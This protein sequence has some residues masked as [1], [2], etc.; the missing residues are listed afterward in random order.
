MNIT[1]ETSTFS[2][3]IKIGLVLFCALL[4]SYAYFPQSYG[5]WNSASRMAL[6]FSIVD[7]GT[8]TINKFKKATGD[9]TQVAG[10]YY[11]DKA[12]GLSFS[13]LPV[14]AIVIPVLKKAGLR[15]RWLD[16]D[17]RLTR[18]AGLITHISVI[19]T[20]GLATAAAAF[21]LYLLVLRMGAGLGSAVFAMLTFG[22]GTLAWGWATA[23]FGHA[24]AGSCLFIAFALI[25]YLD[26]QEEDS[27]HDTL[28]AFMA[29]VLLSWAVVVE[30]TAAIAMLFIALYGVTVALKWH[31]S[32]TKRV[33]ACAVLGGVLAALPLFIYN[34]YAFGGP[35]RVG[36]QT[37]YKEG[38]T[39]MQ[40]GFLGITYPRV[41]VVLQLLFSPYRGLFF[42]SP[43]L[44]ASP[45]AI[46][47]MGR[48]PQYRRMAYVIFLVASYYLLM[49]GA[50]Y[51][52]DGGWS[53]GP[54]H[55][56]PML[57]FLCFP[58]AIAWEH[59]SPLTR[60]VNLALLAVSAA[61][62]FICVSVDMFSPYRYTKPL[63]QYLLP[64]FL[65]G[66]LRTVLLPYMAEG[67]LQLLPPAL[68]GKAAL[69]YCRRVI[70]DI[71]E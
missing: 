29:G 37:V 35:L 16:D 3:P 48:L 57:P 71:H 13:A 61:I 23:F 49:N 51:Y 4:F 1:I 62:S 52:W 30:F 8:I 27:R 15:G 33:L 67:F 14:A 5:N 21:V 2:P 34:S 63:A 43:V 24:M 19:C 18:E 40:Q 42:F 38:F 69:F 26:T 68:V 55:L 59:G 66:N 65:A 50:Y 53:T 31:V 54:R 32:R 70:R 11:S 7:D 25:S 60:K 64:N 17:G 12:P 45:F 36:Y 44:L 39:G 56:V 28:C 10:N 46:Y 58:L 41:G 47:Q 22:L 20:S 9:K 6:V